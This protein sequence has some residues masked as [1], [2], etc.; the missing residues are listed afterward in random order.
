MTN[1]ML[2][3]WK[4]NWR[5]RI[6]RCW[7]WKKKRMPKYLPWT[8]IDNTNDNFTNTSQLVWKLNRINRRDGLCAEYR[9]SFPYLS[10]RAYHFSLSSTSILSF[11]CSSVFRAP[12]ILTLIIQF[13][14]EWAYVCAS[15]CVSFSVVVLVVF[16]IEVAKIPEQTNFKYIIIF[17][18]YSVSNLHTHTLLT[19]HNKIGKY[20]IGSCKIP[21]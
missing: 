6:E 18:R 14:F 2:S 5:Q 16:W 19:T 1:W 20:G 7:M 17:F 12:K 13:G 9:P 15:V 21:T 4:F 11:I 8:A 3:V 10:K